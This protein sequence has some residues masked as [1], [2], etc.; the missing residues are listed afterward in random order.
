M[1][2]FEGLRAIFRAM[3]IHSRLPEEANGHL[4]NVA[5]IVHHKDG[6][7]FHFASRHCTD[8]IFNSL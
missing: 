4:Q 1:D 5:V 7:L 2:F 3:D 8:L 6:G